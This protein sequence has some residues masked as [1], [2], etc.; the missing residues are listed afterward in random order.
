M[1]ISGRGATGHN[2]PA[3]IRQVLPFAAFWFWTWWIE[4]FLCD[5]RARLY[6]INK[7]N[8]F[9][10]SQ[11][12]TSWEF[13]S[14]Y[15]YAKSTYLNERRC[16]SFN[17]IIILWAAQTK[18]QVKYWHKNHF[19]LLNMTLIPPFRLNSLSPCWGNLIL[20]LRFNNG[21]YIPNEPPHFI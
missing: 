11:R 5:H 7:I 12:N 13:Y 20:L 14:K 16:L 10:Q 6:H 1:M 15:V 3:E 2:L 18:L 9:F 21:D 17:N 19:A 8:L 4:R